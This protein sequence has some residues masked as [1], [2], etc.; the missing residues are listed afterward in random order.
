MITRS[1]LLSLFIFLFTPIHAQTYIR[2]LSLENWEGESTPRYWYKGSF[3]YLLRS[4][5]PNDTLAPSDGR[6][7]VFL[8]GE[9]DYSPTTPDFN[10]M[11]IGQQLTMRLDSGYGYIFTLDIAYT[12]YDNY[13]LDVVHFSKYRISYGTL[14]VV[15]SSEQYEEGEVLWQSSVFYHTQWKK[16]T[17]YMEPDKNIN[18]LRFLA[19]KAGPDSAVVSANIDNLTQIYRTLKVNV[20]AENACRE[21]SNG[22]VTAIPTDNR[23]TYTYLWEP[24]GYTTSTVK[25][26]PAGKYHLTINSSGGARAERD[27]EVMTSDVIADVKV[28][29]ASCNGLADGTVNVRTNGGQWPY[30]YALDETEQTTAIFNNVSG[31][32]HKMVVKDKWQCA[33]SADVTISE[34]PPLQQES[35]STKGLTCNASSDGL[36][37]L[38]ISG[39]TLPYIYSIPGSPPQKDSILRHLNAGA[40]H[41]TITDS[42]KCQIEGNTFITGSTRECAVFIPSAFSPNGDGLNDIFHVKFMDGYTAYRLTVYGRW[43]EVVYET[44]DPLSGWDGKYKGV[45]LPTGNYTWSVIYTSSKN[46]LIKRRGSLL[47]IR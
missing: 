31:G 3:G 2:N 27:I 45:N 35:I 1:L 4:S 34:P 36:I 19:F 41:Y 14:M 30:T 21:E 39:G 20:K 9:E 37:T 18:H 13:Y 28:T 23:E 12:P 22:V 42:H 44:N 38:T 5:S 32:T 33:A 40:Y 43:G 17:V 10:P 6:Q 11:A 24:G 46:E 15:G 47:M 25:G 7:Y 16:Y 29:N 26:L 8:T